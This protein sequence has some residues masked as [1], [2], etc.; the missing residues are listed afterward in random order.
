MRSKSSEHQSGRRRNRALATGVATA[1]A[2]SA[3]G[4]ASA[5]GGASLLEPEVGSV[6]VPRHGHVAATARCHDGS[7]VVSGGFA[8]PDVAY[9]GGGPYTDTVGAARDGK[10]RFVSRASNDAFRVGRFYSYAYCGDFGKIVTASGST[11]IDSFKN[12][13]AKARCPG[14]MTAVSGGY[15]GSAPS[16]GR[17]EMVPFLSKRTGTR[18]WKIAAE[19]VAL[20]GTGRLTAFAYCARLDS[21]PSASVNQVRMEGFNKSVGGLLVPGGQR[22]DRRRLRR[23]DAARELDRNLGRDLAAK[24]GRR[25]LEGD[26][27]ERQRP[28]P[29]EGL[30]LLPAPP[31]LSWPVSRCRRTRG[32]ARRASATAA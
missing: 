9:A 29:P 8:T 17:A 7:E 2:L 27:A 23:R 16:G 15:R 10:R 4:I 18:G 1:L 21:A 31:R 6:K 28:A 3:A 26:G 22:G 19:N 5:H 11:T 32:R 25:T 12:G 24:E 13:S 14:G 20:K 30:R